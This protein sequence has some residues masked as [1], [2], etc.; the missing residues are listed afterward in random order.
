M[1]KPGPGSD[2]VAAPLMLKPLESGAVEEAEPL[3][4]SPVM[5]SARLPVKV[6][7]EGGFWLRSGS[8]RGIT[9]DVRA[10]SHRNP[11][12]RCGGGCCGVSCWETTLCCALGETGAHV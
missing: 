9:Y 10:A 4:R 5:R 6:V 12:R 11:W 2:E 8:E 7:S 3:V 1:E